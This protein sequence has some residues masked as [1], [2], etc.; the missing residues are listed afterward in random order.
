MINKFFLL[1]KNIIKIQLLSPLQ[2]FKILS[3][4][5]FFKLAGGDFFLILYQK[6][7]NLEYLIFVQ[8]HYNHHQ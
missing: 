6:V 4:I 3:K 1:F 8:V 2:N 7:R 5:E